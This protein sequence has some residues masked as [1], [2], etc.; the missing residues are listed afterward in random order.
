MACIARHG[1]HNDSTI[2]IIPYFANDIFLLSFHSLYQ[3]KISALEC[4]NGRTRGQW[5]FHITITTN[6]LQFTQEP[7]TH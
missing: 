2:I 5:T 1:Q 3:M 7:H 4:V 6:K